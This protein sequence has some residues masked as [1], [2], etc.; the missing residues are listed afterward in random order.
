M[1]DSNKVKITNKRTGEVSSAQTARS[2]MQWKD[3]K[4]VTQMGAE[5]KNAE[6]GVVEKDAPARDQNKGQSGPPEATSSAKKSS[7]KKA[8]KVEINGLADFI[9]YAYSRKGQNLKSLAPGEVKAITNNARLSEREFDDLLSLSKSDPLLAVP[10]QIVFAMQEIDASP[11]IRGEIRRLVS[12]V[13]KQHPV[14]QHND[15]VPVIANLE[16][17]LEPVEA[18]RKIAKLGHETLASLTGLEQPKTKDAEA[19]RSNA[20]NC[21]AMWLWESRGQQVNR[22]IR[23]LHEGYWSALAPSDTSPTECLQMVTGVTEIPG[24]G[25]ACQLFRKEADESALRVTGLQSKIDSLQGE[26]A[27]LRQ[28]IRDLEGAVEERDRSISGLSLALDAERSDHANSRAHLG[29]DREHLRSNVVRRLKR[30]VSLLTEGLQALRK[31]PP[32]VRVMDDHAERVLEGLQAA[33]KE[34]EEED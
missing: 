25:T 9:T 17:A 20:I 11:Q 10:R 23:W 24:I 2:A 26:I 4:P 3:D 7:K 28:V 6:Q 8:A 12:E 16:D 13:L 5:G 30:E 14:Y 33:M 15:L 19:L 32:K 22:V 29:D 18:I 34:L 27:D 21:L 31:D 1:S